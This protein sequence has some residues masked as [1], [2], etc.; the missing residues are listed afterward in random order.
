MI[1]TRGN[2]IKLLY[3]VAIATA[4]ITPALAQTAPAPSPNAVAD[5]D[6]IVVTGLRQKFR[7]TLTADD[8]PQSIQHVPRDLIDQQGITELTDALILVSG[9]SRQNNYGGAYD[10][11][12]VRGFVGNPNVPSPYLINGYSARGFGGIGDT[13]SV[14]QL[15]IIKGPTSAIY[16]RGE[17]GGTLNLITRKPEFDG[18]GRVA[19]TGG[20]F[21]S[22]RGE[23]D[24]TGPL[25]ENV[26]ARFIA[27]SDHSD[28]FRDF[29]NS[30]RFSLNSSILAKFN[31]T[32]VSYELHY[33][34][35]KF[36]FDRG[37]VAVNGRIDA[38]PTT[39]LLGEPGDGRH[40]ARILTQQL[41]VQQ[42]LGGDWVLIVGRA[43]HKTWL[44]GFHQQTEL[45]GTRQQLLVDGQ[46][47][48][49]QRRFQDF[50]T[51]DTSI[52]AEL[53]GKF[54]TG[55]LTHNIFGG[56]DWARFTLDRFST[57]Y[58]PPLLSTNPTLLQL[59]AINI[60]NPVYGTI[61]PT[62]SL[63]LDDIERQTSYGFYITD[64][65]DI[66]RMLSVR[67]SLRHDR[68]SQSIQ[69]RLNN[70]QLGQS[71]SATSPQ[72]GLTF[73]PSDD[74]QLYGNWGRGFRPNTGRDFLGVVFE[75][76]RIESYEI[77]TK[78]ALFNKRLTGTL[79]AFTMRKTGIIV[80]DVRNPA[81]SVAAGSARSKGVELDLLGRLP[82]D[83][84]IRANYAFI[85]SAIDQTIPGVVI[86]GTPLL[87]IARHSGNILIDKG[88]VVGG[89]KAQVG[90]GV[91]HV[92]TRRGEAAFDFNLPAYTLVKLNGSVDLTQNLVVSAIVSNLF[93][94]RHYLNSFSRLWINPGPP[95][96]FSIRLAH[97]F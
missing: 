72:V 46:N 7:A 68:F 5:D 50:N 11:Y 28:T 84:S 3:L 71:E 74:I 1:K 95:R 48:T 62:G 47:L 82:G 57:R 19:L 53:S 10:A 22:F 88:F 64:Q 80:S 17:P 77:G 42:G 38:L 31:N 25:S 70:T 18:A 79:A 23:I 4:S 78:F 20:S 85:D 37:I 52:R 15:E 24:V 32:T 90:I 8:I 58:L 63:L 45:G 34:E 54:K 27:A 66:S 89:R 55:G 93:N 92:G 73:S 21:D 12:A 60:F 26:A 6:A 43:S 67:F 49:R 29:H 44:K 87:N 83:I 40:H 39:R 91:N 94:E 33:S 97:S 30:D 35:Q 86:A 13:A 2:I 59:N 56:G 9:F 96:E 51:S 14:T 36:V 76:E 75:P 61:Q 16:G 81:F 69:V 41:E 65:I